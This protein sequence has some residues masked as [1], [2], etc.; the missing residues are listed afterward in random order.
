M[1]RPPSLQGALPDG[2]P[3]HLPPPLQAAEKLPIAADQRLQHALDRVGQVVR[4][5]WH[6]DAVI[7]VGGTAAVYAATHRKGKRDALK[8]LHP[9]LSAIPEM[10]Q[11]FVDEGYVANSVE[12]PGAVSVIDDDVTE[13]GHVFLIMD[14][15]EGETLDQMVGEGG[16][17]LPARVLTIADDVLDILAAAHDKG[18]VH[19]DVK[20]DNI[21]MTHEGKVRLLDFGIARMKSLARTHGT[22]TGG[23][24]GTPAFMPPEQARGQWDQLDGRTD[25]WALGATMFFLV[26]GRDV[27]QANSVNE[28]LLAA[29]TKPAPSLGDLA[30]H[31]PMPL[32]ELVDRALAFEQADR[33]PSAR[34]MQ[35]AVRRVKDLLASGPMTLPSHENAIVATTPTLVTPSLELRRRKLPVSSS[36][37]VS[38]SSSR[39]RA[40]SPALLIAL[41]AAISFAALFAIRQVRHTFRAGGAPA[42]A[43]VLD[44]AS[45]DLGAP[46]SAEWLAFAA[47]P[48]DPGTAATSTTSNPPPNEPST[49]PAKVNSDRLRRKVAPRSPADPRALVP[50]EAPS[51]PTALSPEPIRAPRAPVD[52]LERRK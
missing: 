30:P 43:V 36:P 40:T 34:E 48:I 37:A 51:P 4:D 16:W 8:V 52:P 13:D 49:S 19:R 41:S 9:E 2:S 50:S 6:L 17:L 7:G 23:A 18:I 28:E 31:L 11:R 20:P 24:L 14:L 21:F 32:I 47:A 27:H 42:P 25:L 44:E 38:R 39:T 35:G 22:E 46:S 15:L 26:T 29:M 10:R 33:W 12:H 5:R 3:G 45:P 1:D